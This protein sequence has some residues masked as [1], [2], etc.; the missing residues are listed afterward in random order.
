ML[1]LYCTEC[2]FM[3]ALAVFLLTN[4]KESVAVENVNKIGN[5]RVT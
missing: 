1:D 4:L 2:D 3:S 5:V